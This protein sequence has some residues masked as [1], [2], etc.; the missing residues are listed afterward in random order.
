MVL[1]EAAAS[2]LPV[3]ATDVGGNAEIV[4]DG[5]TGRLV[6]PHDPAALAAAMS[7]TMALPATERAAWGRSGRAHVAAEFDLARV[8][9]AWIA[10]YRRLRAGAPTE[11][12]R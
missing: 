11:A 8:A 2:G 1:L 10:L 12:H 9:D 3:V 7:E 4:L 6:P 5:T